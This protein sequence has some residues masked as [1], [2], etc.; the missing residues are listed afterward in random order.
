MLFV[1]FGSVSVSAADGDSSFVEDTDLRNWEIEGDGVISC[2]SGI[3][4]FKLNGSKL[5]DGVNTVYVHSLVGY[6]DT[7][8]KSGNSYSVKFVI[9]SYK[10]IQPVFHPNFSEE[11]YYAQFPDESNQIC[12]NIGLGFLGD[13]GSFEYYPDYYVSLT[14]P[15]MLKY[16]DKEYTYTFELKDFKGS[17]PLFGISFV[18]VNSLENNWLYIK[19]PVFIDESQAEEDGFFARL[20]QWFQEKFDNLKSWFSNLGDSIGGFFADLGNKISGFFSDLGDKLSGFFNNLSDWLT[21]LKNS[22]TAKIEAVVEDIKGF[23]I[24]D[25][26]FVSNWRSD[27]ESLLAE[28]LGVVYDVADFFIDF[29]STIFDLLSHSSDFELNF[30]LPKLEFEIGEQSY[31]LWEDTAVDMSF[32]SND[33]IFKV[34]YTMYKVI[35]YIILAFLLFNHAKNVGRRT[36]NN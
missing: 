6:D 18:T 14:K 36:M 22:I 7:T 21:D 35:L 15:D 2:Y 30:V 31:V 17:Q 28:H 29:I 23:F 20:F 13:D 27:M 12:F 19:Q 24:P 4:S 10:T 34:L 3:Y 9:P 33:G 32:L 1:N 5:G 26:E 16:A 25:E 8:I 11:Q